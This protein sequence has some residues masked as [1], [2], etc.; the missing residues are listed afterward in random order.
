[1]KLEN[2]SFFFFFKLWCVYYKN[3]CHCSSLRDKMLEMHSALIG[4]FNM[5]GSGTLRLHSSTTR[6]DIEDARN[7]DYGFQKTWCIVHPG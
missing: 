1:M 5:L 3:I 4:Q 7:P 2:E 6:T